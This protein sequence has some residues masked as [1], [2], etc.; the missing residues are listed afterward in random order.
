MRTLLEQWRDRVERDLKGADFEE[1]LVHEAVDGLRTQPLYTRLDCEDLDLGTMPGAWP[2]M[3]GRADGA[4][5]IWQSVA[6]PDPALAARHASEELSRGAHGLHLEVDVEGRSSRGV[7]LRTRDEVEAFLAAL[8]GAELA[9]SVDSGAHFMALSAALLQQA[10]AQGRQLRGTLGA[11][12]VGVLATEGFLQ[13]GSRCLSWVGDLAAAC[14]EQAPQLRAACADGS[15]WHEAGASD[16]DEL[17]FVLA[18]GLTLVRALEGEGL[19]LPRAFSQI[20]FRL[21][22]SPQALQG[23]AKVRA[24]RAGW[25][26]I[27]D[28]CG[29]G[30]HPAGRAFIQVLPGRRALTQRDPWV[31]LLRN[32]AVAFGG[33]AGGADAVTTLSLDDALGPPGDLGRRIARNTQS[34]LALE[35]HLGRVA[36]PA[37][38][39]YFLER[40]TADLL[41]RAWTR[42][43]AVEALGGSFRRCSRGR[44]GACWPCGRPAGHSGWPTVCSRSPA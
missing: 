14:A 44:W 8:P 7:R 43:Q 9:L 16:G 41:E 20:A 29:I 18:T 15:P 19:D 12:P 35:S 24:L 17:G 30:G 13:G 31:N 23:M 42:M 37:G 11:D 6:T 39:S 4:W 36:D 25:G 22:L 1:R 33:A 40:R 3:R 32:T 21:R 28:A 27:A 5:Q 2:W 38:G 10:R 34:I 26:R